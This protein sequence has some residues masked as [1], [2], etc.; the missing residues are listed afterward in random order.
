[1]P[2][3]APILALVLLVASCA[4]APSFLLTNRESMDITIEE[5]NA[6]LVK[7]IADWKMRHKK[8]KL[9]R[10]IKHFEFCARSSVRHIS[11]V[12]SYNEILSTLSRGYYLL[13][14][15]H[16]R[17]LTMKKRYWETGAFWAEKALFLN[18]RFKKAVGEYGEYVPA[19]KYTKSSQTHAMYWYLANIGKWAKNSGIATS[20]KYLKLI[21]A[22]IARIKHFDAKFFH[23]A[24][25]RYWGAYYALIP[26][27]AGGDLRKSK[28]YFERSLKIA[29]KYLGTRVLYAQSYALKV[30]N[31]V[32]YRRLLQG[33]VAYELDPESDI[34]SENI[35]EKNKAKKLLKEMNEYF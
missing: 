11:S 31:K 33:V 3:Y 5:Y 9:E 13:A 1:M 15:N 28:W 16:E 20:L 6:H 18:P 2:F 27:F 17:H 4:N 32:L 14:N 8:S 12:M 19:L 25:P 35:L 7:G 22:M 23:G 26:I 34:Y 10:F 29:P 30:R 24:V 21:K